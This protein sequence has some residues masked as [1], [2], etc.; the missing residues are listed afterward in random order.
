MILFKFLIINII[1]LYVIFR[2]GMLASRFFNKKSLGSIMSNGFIIYFALFEIISAPF[3]FFHLN[4][5]IIFYIFILYTL[6]LVII[7]YLKGNKKSFFSYK[8]FLK[9]DSDKKL[10]SCFTTALI[11]IQVFL[12]CYLFHSDADDS[13][14][15]SLINSSINNPHLYASDPSTGVQTFPLMSQ[16]IFESWELFQAIIAKIFNLS[17]PI[18]AHTVIPCFLILCAYFVCYYFAETLGFKENPHIFVFFMC[19]LNIMG[20]YSDYS[21]SFFLLSRVWQGKSVVV[22]IMFPLIYIYFKM[23]LEDESK[24]LPIIMLTLVSISGI[25][26]NPIIVYLMPLLLASIAIWTVFTHKNIKSFF[27]SVMKYIITIMPLVFFALLIKLHISKS[28]I[29]DNPAE[30]LKNF[31]SVLIFNNFFLSKRFLILFLICIIYL[32]LYGSKYIK[33]IAAGSPFVLLVL[34]F[35]PKLAPFVAQYLTSFPTYWRVFWLLPITYIIAY[36]FTHFA[37]DKAFF[38]EKRVRTIIIIML[39]M[40]IVLAGKKVYSKEY[41]FS[42]P[43]NAYKIPQEIVNVTLHINDISKKNPLVLAPEEINTTMRQLTNSVTLFRSRDFYLQEFL[44]ST[45]EKNIYDEREELYNYAYSGNLNNDRFKEL[46]KKY[47][48]DIIIVN[49]NAVKDVSSLKNNNL[50]LDKETSNYLVYSITK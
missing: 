29:F 18:V 28:Y 22:N 20:G 32:L 10:M 17:A 27:N 8:A 30:A 46:I 25:A 45:G 4:F 33:I 39:T 23:H 6:L 24:K 9:L 1:L 50:K 3:I 5:N 36:T 37:E 40:I 11:G 48:I 19:V 35:N 31:S 13:F 2:T 7:S 15:V 12:S 43:E 21:S 42:K 34:V 14:Y 38:E 26:F 41:A 16:Y 44:I 47:D 49:K